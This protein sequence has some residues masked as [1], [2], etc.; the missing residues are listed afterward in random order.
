MT[1]CDRL[2]PTMTRYARLLPAVAKNS[3][4]W[5]LL[6]LVGQIFSKKHEFQMFFP[7]CY[8]KFGSHNQPTFFM[9]ANSKTHVITQSAAIDIGFYSVKVALAKTSGD[10]TTQILTKSFPSFAP[11]IEG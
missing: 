5:S 6:V 8:L 2:W 4:N 9:T 7:S 3:H 10:V 1:V 11:R